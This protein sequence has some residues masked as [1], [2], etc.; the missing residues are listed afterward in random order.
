M[1][2]VSAERRTYTSEGWGLCLGGIEFVEGEE[3]AVSG[4]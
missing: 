2:D 3:D 4:T 1:C